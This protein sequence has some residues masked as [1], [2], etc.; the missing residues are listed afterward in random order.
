[1]TTFAPIVLFVYNRLEHT[2]KTVEALQKNLLAENS[3]LFI[4]SDSYKDIEQ[5]DKVQEVRNY[6]KTIFGFK[7]VNIIEREK[8]YGLADSIIS[9]VTEVVNKFGA[10]IV[11]EDDLITSPYFLKYMNEGLN[12]YRNEEK[13]IAIHA[14]TYPVKEKLPNTFFLKNP[15]CWGWATWERGWKLFEPDGK[16]L[17]DKLQEKNLIEEFDFDNSYH[18]SETLR[19]QA[20]GSKNSWAIR[21]YATTFLANKL[22]LYPK[23]SLV[24]NIGFDGTGVHLDVSN[25]YDTN[26]LAQNINV[27]KIDV[28]E[29]KLAKTA[30]EKYFLSIRAGFLKRLGWKLKALTKWIKKNE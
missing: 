10:V 7:K 3:E 6:L 9:G 8:N 30:F 27:E 2:K 1:M 16:K 28:V 22:T 23:Q 25:S 15:G 18:F 19:R 12:S 13:V 24:Q 11:L 17:L 4:F 14:Y 29:N 5:Q 26:N 20:L 21:W